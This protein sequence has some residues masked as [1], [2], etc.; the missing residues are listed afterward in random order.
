MHYFPGRSHGFSTSASHARQ[1]PPRDVQCVCANTSRHLVQ[2]SSVG[3]V[4]SSSRRPLVFFRLVTCI[5]TKQT[6]KF[7]WNF[8]KHVSFN[9]PYTEVLEPQ[10]ELSLGSFMKQQQPAAQQHEQIYVLFFNTTSATL[11]SKRTLFFSHNK[12]AST[13]A[14]ETI[15]RVKLFFSTSRKDMSWN[16]AENN[17]LSYIFPS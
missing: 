13:A 15:S 3:L 8:H 14:V 7:C 9:R 11:F 2:S 4:L 6:D 12:S 10:Q 5:Y 16:E 17:S 1:S